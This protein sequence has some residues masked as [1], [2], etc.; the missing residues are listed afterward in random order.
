[1]NYKQNKLHI[2]SLLFGIYNKLN[3]QRKIQINLF[4]ALMI[5]NAI[6]ESITITLSVPFIAVLVNPSSLWDIKPLKN[7]AID[8]GFNSAS[9]FLLPLTISF[10]I[11]IV[12]CAL[13]RLLNIWINC[14][15][16]AKI[17]ND[18]SKIA[19]G[20]ILNQKYLYH[21]N[22][23]SSELISSL[24]VK[25]TYTL[26][27]LYSFLQ[28]ILSVFISFGILFTLLLV[29]WKSALISG[30]LFICIYCL[31]S[32]KSKK[33]LQNN[34][35]LIAKSTDM[36]IKS[37]QNSFGSIRD[38]LLDR[39]Q[40]TYIKIYSDIDQE[41]R[42]RNAENQ[43]LGVFPKYILEA[44]SICIISLLSVLLINNEDTKSLAIAMIGTL[45]LGAQRLLPVIQL[46]Y[47]S[48]AGITSKSSEMRDVLEI[49]ELS[50]IN[51]KSGIKN[52]FS[53]FNKSLRFDNVNF[54]YPSRI[55]YIFSGLTV[56]FPIGKT[57]GI[58][59]KTGSGKSTLLDLILGLLAPNKGKVLIDS[60]DIHSDQNLSK[61][62][63]SIAHVPQDVYILDGDFYENIAF[64]YRKENIDFK[65][66]REVARISMLEKFIEGLEDCY[67]TNLGERGVQ[68]SGGQ[69]QRIGIARAL[70]K[71]TD[72]LILDEAT[73]AL[74]E[75]IEKQILDNILLNKKKK[76]IFMVT[77]RISTLDRCEIVF[78]V[79]GSNIFRKTIL[80]NNKD[81]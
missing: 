26:E 44:F 60:N 62:Q 10:C 14:K 57:I 41:I 71:E 11:A 4:I 33:I 20:N 45:A 77:H 6:A 30:I 35:N 9:N 28:L 52:S 8:M 79:S 42:K 5:I 37:I 54:K 51:N 66:V 32:L 40:N 80:K 38:I 36:Q 1:M 39:L 31:I 22:T 25:M 24:T 47:N 73:S 16:I 49:L 17:G 55:D 23:K 72:I 68:L 61:W 74:D 78:E 43:F 3:K 29:S 27:A 76:T 64:G 70:Y 50:E 56:E 46:I 67:T 48:W 58:I 59:G 75:L 13:I 53:N 81:N 18:L 65:K 12:I 63:D 34:S 15:L 69:R 7:F 21:L 19:Y 2:I